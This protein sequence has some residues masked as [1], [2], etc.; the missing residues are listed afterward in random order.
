MH[1]TTTNAY[2]VDLHA[3]HSEEMQSRFCDG[4]CSGEREFAV[5][6]AEHFLELARNKSLADPVPE[7]FVPGL[8]E[9]TVLR[10][11][12]PNT[13][14]KV[15][16]FALDARHRMSFQGRKDLL[17]DLLPH[18]GNTQ[19][20]R[21]LHSSQSVC[22]CAFA[23]I[24][25]SCNVDM[26]PARSPCCGHNG[27]D[28]VDHHASNVGQRQERQNSFFVRTVEQVMLEALDHAACFEDDVVV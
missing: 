20:E 28:N 6:Q 21:W 5:G 12:K 27:G 17:H 25:R 4:G 13:L 2:L 24:V 7:R 26:H 16:D 8:S 3:E 11:P 18:S 9:L 23:Q 22:E 15:C 1:T 19:E 10:K 14:S